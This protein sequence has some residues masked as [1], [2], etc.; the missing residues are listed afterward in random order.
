MQKVNKFFGTI[1]ILGIIDMARAEN[2]CFKKVPVETFYFCKKKRIKSKKK[3]NEIL[4][5]IYV[6][7]C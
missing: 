3:K 1:L 4:N 2:L 5:K 7:E 6:I